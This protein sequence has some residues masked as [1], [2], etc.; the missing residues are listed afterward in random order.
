MVASLGDDYD[1]YVVAGDKDF[2]ELSPIPGVVSNQWQQVGK[3]KVMYLSADQIN[4]NRFQEIHNEVNPQ[5]IYLNSLFSKDFTLL[6]LRLFSKNNAVVVAPRGMLGESS[7]KIKA[8]KKKVFLNLAKVLGWYKNV[9]WHASTEQEKLEI[10]NCFGKNVD[11]KVASNLPHVPEEWY[12]EVAKQKGVLNMIS[13]GRIV[14]IKNIQFMISVLLGVKEGKVR[15]ELIGPLEDLNYVNQCKQLIERLPNNVEVELLGEVKPD[16]IGNYYKNAHVYFSATLNENYGHGIVEA[17]G[18]GCPLVISNR[19]PWKHLE[20][21]GVGFDCELVKEDFL[22]R[23][24][25]FLELTGEEYHLYRKRSRD[26]ALSQIQESNLVEDN[27][28]VF[29]IS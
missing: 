21:K 8:T 6:P 20:D 10:E 13:V 5:V 2:G 9:M 7:L 26:L 4:K 3:A 11:V 27:K 24:K 1:I 14:P 23:I 16:D 18:Y 28:N 29:R 12:P 22:E 15:L 19:T 17:L 25:Y